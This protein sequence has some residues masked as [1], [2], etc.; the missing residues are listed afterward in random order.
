MAKRNVRVDIPRSSTE[1]ILKLSERIF[2]RHTE[3]G[4]ESPLHHEELADI[5][6]KV[7]AA[8]AHLKKAGKL[9][10]E[11]EAETQHALNIIGIAKGQTIKTKGTL[12]NKIG[13][14]RSIL[15]VHHEN[16]EEEIS[17]YGYNVVIS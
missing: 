3:L 13:R 6:D 14:G 2:E 4:D 11:A 8:R 9:H 15:V 10:E 5:P 1:K 7:A 16:E 12:Y 17:K